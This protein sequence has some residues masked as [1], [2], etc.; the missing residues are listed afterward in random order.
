MLSLDVL[1]GATVVSE[2]TNPHEALTWTRNQ[3][4]HGDR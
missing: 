2:K 4:N 1:F 3:S